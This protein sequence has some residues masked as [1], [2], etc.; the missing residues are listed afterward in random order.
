[1]I[2]ANAVAVSGRLLKIAAVPA[3][4]ERF[5]EIQEPEKIIRE[6]RRRRVDLFTFCQLLPDLKPKHPYY[7]EWD[8]LACIPLTSYERWLTEQIPKST[9]REVRKS[10][11]SGLALR[12]TPFDDQL[13]QGITALFNESPIRQGR[14]FAH[15]G[16][17]FNQVKAEW[18]KQSS[19]SVFI[20]AYYEDALIGF[21]KLIFMDKGYAYASGTICSLAHRDKSPMNGLIAKAV[22]ICVARGLTHLVYGKFSY[23]SKGPD[24]LSEFKRRN[25]FIRMDF[26][27]YY[28]PLTLWGEW[29]LRLRLHRSARELVPHRLAKWLVGVRRRSYE[30]V[31]QGPKITWRA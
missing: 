10:L 5:H 6:L 4:E 2:A 23:G 22:E 3:D 15:Y 17:G 26:P 30:L 25:G 13:V 7:F 16:K 21:I 27:R 11:N 20:C 1:M 9:R 29:A 12:L 19:Q 24:S 28:V 8:N 14:R 31:G 18:S